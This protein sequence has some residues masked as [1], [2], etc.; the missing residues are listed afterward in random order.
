[1]PSIWARLQTK[2]RPGRAGVGRIAQARHG[3]APSHMPGVSSA[4]RK[5]F[6]EAL[7]PRGPGGRFAAKPKAENA[8]S[9]PAG[10]TRQLVGDE[11]LKTSGIT[12]ADEIH[13]L[14][15]RVRKY[16]GHATVEAFV[17]SHPKGRAYA[18]R[19]LAADHKAG[20]IGFNAATATE[21]PAKANTAPTAPAPKAHPPVKIDPKLADGS[22]RAH[23][24]SVTSGLQGDDFLISL[25]GSKRYPMGVTVEQIIGSHAKGRAAGL[26]QIAADMKAGRL[27][28]ERD[29]SK[30]APEKRPERKPAP[31]ATVMPGD[32]RFNFGEG[33]SEGHKR[34]VRETYGK[35]PE[36]M[37]TAL[38]DKGYSFH[39]PLRSSQYDP[40]LSQVQGQATAAM[41][42]S[43]TLE[44]AQGFFEPTRKHIVVND[45]H[46]DTF[47]GRQSYMPNFSTGHVLMH[48]TGHA[49][50]QMAGYASSS[51]EFAAAHAADLADFN[52]RGGL[53][54]DPGLTYFLQHG[55]VGR[56]ESFAEIF[57]EHFVQRHQ[58]ADM[59]T[60]FPRSSAF[61]S[62]LIERI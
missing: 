58:S 47:G 11:R 37:R 15:K 23:T 48:E 34:I 39:A 54:A 59:R 3:G 26:K 12:G 60:K 8:A 22:F 13:V 56:S 2:A 21:A 57:A 20:R 50:D 4:V 25:N 32:E 5:A 55:R 28:A 31:A 27:Q 6:Q 45:T 18:L 19:T 46:L 49:V 24:V 53:K 52:Q 17:A 44:N 38:G 43:R 29:K 42:S 14:S 51:P 10:S 1:M 30:I 33:V 41:K 62:K 9:K 61:V 40:A 7:H 16:Q 35:L 36:R